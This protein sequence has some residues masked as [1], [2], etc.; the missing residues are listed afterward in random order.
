MGLAALS[1]AVEWLAP[2]FKGSTL[3]VAAVDNAAHAV[4]A[5]ATW[6]AVLVAAA[7]DSRDVRRLVRD[8]LAAAIVGSA[9]D[10][11]HFVAAGSLSL[12]AATRLQ[13][14]PW[15]HSVL[16]VIALPALVVPLSTSAALLIATSVASHQCRDAQRRG[17]WLARTWH[18]PPLSRPAYLVSLVCLALLASRAMLLTGDLRPNLRFEDSDCR[19]DLEDARPLR[20]PTATWRAAAAT[21]ARPLSRRL[22]V[23]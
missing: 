21:P 19:H 23:V 17:F 2:R 22:A 15:L 11:D 14:R 5:A 3:V 8:T 6:L 20:V 18:T 1:Q 13:S 10:L 9:V 4:V 7:A 16:A 12:R